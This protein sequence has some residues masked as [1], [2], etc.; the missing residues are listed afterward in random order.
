MKNFLDFWPNFLPK[1]DWIW[2]ELSKYYNLELSETPDILFYSVWT[3]NESKIKQ[4]ELLQKNPKCIRIFYTPENIRPNFDECD[5]ALSF[6]YTNNPKNIRL[7]YYA[8]VT[9]MNVENISYD[10]LTYEFK[11]DHINDN[12]FKKTKFCCTVM[13][14]P[15]PNSNLRHIFFEELSKYKKVDSAGKHLNNIDYV[16]NGWMKEKQDF[17]KDY[18][19][20]MS[21]ENEQYPGY[22][23]EK[24][25]EPMCVGSIPIYYGNPLIHEDFNIESFINVKN[26]DD[27]NN[28]IN[29]IIEIDNNDDLFLNIQKKTNLIDNKI[30]DFQNTTILINKLISMIEEKLN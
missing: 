3:T 4:Y 9:M 10:R 17:I 24:I 26:Y 13:S 7:P 23:T 12:I 21:F 2:Y 1:Q 25:I 22:A 11:N 28:A 19:F 5:I 29:K 27:I 18:K 6:D 15:Y 8:V 16:L 30:Q 20:V 14:N